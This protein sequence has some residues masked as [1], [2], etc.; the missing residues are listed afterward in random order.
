VGLKVVD[1]LRRQRELRHFNA[2]M[3][4]QPAAFEDGRQFFRRLRLV[5]PAEGRRRGQGARARTADRMAARA[6]LRRQLAAFDRCPASER[7]PSPAESSAGAWKQSSISGSR[8]HPFVAASVRHED[9]DHH[10]AEQRR[11]TPPTID[12]Q[13]RVAE[14]AGD[15]EIG[16]QVLHCA[17]T[18]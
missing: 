3:L 10:L 16:A 2:S 7:R 9:G 6:V 18:T 17:S 5:Q 14:G 13:A 12:P 11:L 15:H 8:R 1:L 4:R